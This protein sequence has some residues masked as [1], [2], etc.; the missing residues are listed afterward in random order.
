MQLDFLLVSIFLKFAMT[1]KC[2]TNFTDQILK[3]STKVYLKKLQGEGKGT[4]KGN[5]PLIKPKNV[6][7]MPTCYR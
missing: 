5:C 3:S 1:R 2:E 6:W 4:F 7:S